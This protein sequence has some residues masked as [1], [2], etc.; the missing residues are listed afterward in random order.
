MR[1]RTRKFRNYITDL[2]RAY[3]R[4]T[5]GGQSFPDVLCAS[6]FPTRFGGYLR[7]AN[8]FLNQFLYPIL[9]AGESWPTCTEAEWSPLVSGCPLSLAHP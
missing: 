7:Q 9:P 5:Q 4:E 6:L 2:I 1:V 8:P 3:V